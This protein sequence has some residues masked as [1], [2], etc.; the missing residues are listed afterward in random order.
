M[1]TALQQLIER[2]ALPIIGKQDFARFIA[3]TKPSVLFFAESP[4][5]Y[6][7]TADVACVLPEIVKAFPGLRAAL[8]DAEH[9]HALQEQFDFTRWPSLA[10]FRDGRYLGAISGILTWEDY[11]LRIQR[12]LD[13]NALPVLNI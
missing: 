2:H 12:L 7:E 8:V 5:R 11:Q 1:S 3:D 10:F 13:E 6:P 4:D 9:E